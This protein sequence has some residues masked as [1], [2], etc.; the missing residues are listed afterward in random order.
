[1]ASSTENKYVIFKL[2]IEHYGIPI[3][4]VLSIER[5]SKMTRIPN[6]PEYILG[7]IN[8]RGDVVP[9]IDLS[10][11]LGLDSSEIDNNTRV[12]IVKENEIVVG[13]MVDSSSEVLEISDEDIDKPPVS[14]SN[15]LLNYV[16]GIGKT[17]LDRMIIILN[18]QKLLEN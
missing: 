5:T 13:L 11:K 18:I 6:S 17:S 14:E 4:N 1:M 10:Y 16:N 8:L 2:G 9:V 12:I 7:L 15:E 3:N